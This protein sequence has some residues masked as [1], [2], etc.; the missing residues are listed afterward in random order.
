MANTELLRATLRH[1]RAHPDAWIQIDYRRGRAGCFAYH[2]AMLAGGQLAHPAASIDRPSG[3]G[4]W[5]N[6][7]PYLVCNRAARDLGFA[8]D[9]VVH[10]ADFARRALDLDDA[11]ARS[12]FSADNTL[13]DLERLVQIHDARRP[14]SSPESR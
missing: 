8:R 1:I 2:A 13:D 10:I 12:L 3:D 5:P 9:E 11:S 14:G 4:S 7:D 6:H